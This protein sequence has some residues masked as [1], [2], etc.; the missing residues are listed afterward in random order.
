MTRREGRPSTGYLLSRFV[1]NSFKTV[2][3]GVLAG[4]S[5]LL[6]RPDAARKFLVRA[7]RSCGYLYQIPRS[8]FG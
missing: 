5:A 8:L 3:F 4:V 2:G 7:R 6:F 1:A